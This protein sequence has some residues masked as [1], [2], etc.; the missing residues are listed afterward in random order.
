MQLVFLLLKS[1][2]LLHRLKTSKYEAARDVLTARFTHV[3]WVSFI[4]YVILS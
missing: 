1:A 2:V 3:V 4:Q